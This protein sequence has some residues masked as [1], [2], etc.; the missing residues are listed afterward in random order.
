MKIAVSLFIIIFFYGNADAFL[1][2]NKLKSLFNAEMN[3]VKSEIDTVKTDLKASIKLQNKM[4]SKIS[5]IDKSISQ[6]FSSGRDTISIVND[7]KILYGVIGVL[8]TIIAGLLGTI[9]YL[10]VQINRRMNRII[11]IENKKNEYKQK[12]YKAING[13]GVKQ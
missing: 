13:R 12:Y 4:N 6:S 5:G 9:R 7:P 1:G 10:I 2:L 3:A 11:E 8:S